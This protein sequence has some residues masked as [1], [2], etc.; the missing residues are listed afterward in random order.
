MEP[1]SGAPFHIALLKGTTFCELQK[2]VIHLTDD[3]TQPVDSDFLAEIGA[4]S[5]IMDTLSRVGEV[6]I[7]LQASN[8]AIVAQFSAYFAAAYERQVVQLKIM[9]MA[10][11]GE[12]VGIH[13]PKI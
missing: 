2:L 5:K 11:A 8:E 4:D 3:N 13:E 10:P 7:E 1:S 9:D 6:K 12:N